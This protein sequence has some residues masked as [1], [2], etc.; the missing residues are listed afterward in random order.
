MRPP[1]RNNDDEAEKRQRRQ[2]LVEQSR[3]RKSFGRPSAAASASIGPASST[4]DPPPAT[5]GLSPEE[6]NRRFEEWMKIAADNKINAGN[7]W[8]L[9]L[10][11]Y[12][13]DMTLL[14]E[15]DSINFTKASCTLD[16]CVKIYISRVDSV[17]GEARKLYSGLVD[18][19]AEMRSHRR[20]GN[21]SGDEGGSGDEGN[22]NGNGLAKKTRKRTQRVGRTLETDINALNVKKFDSD[23]M[24]DPLFRKTSADFDEGGARGLL[25]NHLCIS[26][27]GHMIFDASD[28]KVVQYN[29]NNHVESTKV[30]ITKLKSDFGATL[31]TIWNRDICPSLKSFEFSTV[32]ASAGLPFDPSKLIPDRP[33]VDKDSNGVPSGNENNHS[34]N[35][36]DSDDDPFAAYDDT[37]H[38]GLGSGDGGHGDLIMDEDIAPGIDMEEDMGSHD[39]ND[40]AH[41]DQQQTEFVKGTLGEAHYVISNEPEDDGLFSYFD[42]QMKKGWAGPEHWR[43]RAMAKAKSMTPAASATKKGRKSK[44]PFTIDFVNGTPPNLEQLFAP[45]SAANTLSKSALAITAKTKNL[46]PDDIHYSS[47]DLLQLFLKPDCTIKF[48]RK[49]GSTKV[50]TNAHGVDGHFDPF[51][52]ARGNDEE[53]VAGNNGTLHDHGAYPDDPFGFDD[54]DDDMDD[55]M[56]PTQQSELVGDDDLAGM[57]AAPRDDSMPASFMREQDFGS[58]LVEKPKKVR[59]IPLNYARAAKRVDV[60][61]LKRNLWLELIR[62]PSSKPR[63][64]DPFMDPDTPSTPSLPQ[65]DEQVPDQRRFSDVVHQLRG[66]YPERKLLDISAAF[67]FI[68]VLHLANDNHLKMEGQS[69]LD[70][71]VIMQG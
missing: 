17:D 41:V 59:I 42:S 63:G 46:L 68:C 44:E 18:S 71:F 51:N 39:V 20:A 26:N 67:C 56:A 6:V 30:D 1:V 47:K 65:S 38:S 48:R 57:R 45:G 10:I 3:R 50:A 32:N 61:A 5:Q 13:H 49:D 34:M 12:F 55:A 70:D 31:A 4:D 27:T 54:D 28:A 36:D 9:A 69:D 7:S 62:N 15:G 53:Q 21:D 8:N 22:E 14:K 19:T 64:A 24:V 58:Q 16:G 43:M 25:L 35:D 66:V 60:R 2:S 33:P 52:L 29:E 11:D 37:P 40:Q 23:F